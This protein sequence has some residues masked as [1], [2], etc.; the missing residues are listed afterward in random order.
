MVKRRTGKRGKI[1]QGIDTP[2]NYAVAD[3]DKSTLEMVKQAVAHKEVL[4]AFQPVV[5][6]REPT[7]PAFYEGLIR[8]LDETGRIIPAREFM[9]VIEDNELGR[10]IDALTL[11]MGLTALG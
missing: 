4:L 1:S 8:V 7:T 11:R 3:R 6:T 10:E 9:P 5:Q 2:I